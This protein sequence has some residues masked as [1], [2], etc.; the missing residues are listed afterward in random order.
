MVLI[1]LH[2]KK[3]SANTL[4]LKSNPLLYSDLGFFCLNL[5]TSKIIPSYEIIYVIRF[6]STDGKVMAAADELH[7]CEF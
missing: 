1:L 6:I 7:S 2:K 4:P 5:I 3:S